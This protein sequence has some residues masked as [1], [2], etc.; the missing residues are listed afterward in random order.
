MTKRVFEDKY[1]QKDITEVPE[2]QDYV[3]P[4]TVKA[5]IKDLE[6]RGWAE[7]D[8]LP[9]WRSRAKVGVHRRSGVY[10]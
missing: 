8:I 4:E 9:I 5:W 2:S 7:H 3:G 6:A 10:A 1:G